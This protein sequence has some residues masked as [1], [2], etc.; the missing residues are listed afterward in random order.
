M[1]A[2][3]DLDLE[4]DAGTLLDKDHTFSLMVAEKR[5][6]AA[7]AWVERVRYRPDGIE[8]VAGIGGGAEVRA[9][10]RAGT[11]ASIVRAVA[12]ALAEIEQQYS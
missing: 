11:P 9:T 3:D 6:G 4:L 2:K 10:Y 8:V 1:I 7:R 12:M 5:A